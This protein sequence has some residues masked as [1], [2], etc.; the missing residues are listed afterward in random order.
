M[1]KR[2]IWCF[3]KDISPWKLLRFLA[4][5]HHEVKC[6][7]SLKIYADPRDMKKIFFLKTLVIE[8]SNY[9]VMSV[10]LNTDAN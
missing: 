3:F 6:R 8:W 9:K 1:R 5:L 10:N 7:P 4:Q 2:V